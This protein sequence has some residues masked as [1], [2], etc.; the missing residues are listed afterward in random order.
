M[1]LGRRRLNC[2]RAS[3][4]WMRE[5]FRVVRAAHVLLKALVPKRSL[6]MPVAKLRFAARYQPRAS[7]TSREAEL[8][9]RRSQALLGNERRAG[10]QQSKPRTQRSGVSDL[11]C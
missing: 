3:I 6:G 1:A 9:D 4:K 2:V 5:W 10:F 8:P 11:L 7:P